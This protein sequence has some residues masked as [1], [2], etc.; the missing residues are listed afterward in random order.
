M[1]TILID[2]TAG[3]RGQVE[4]RVERRSEQLAV[5]GPARSMGPEDLGRGRSEP[6]RATSRFNQRGLNILF[7]QGYRYP[8]GASLGGFTI[9]DVEPTQFLSK[10][11]RRAAFG[12][13]PSVR[14]VR[15]QRTDLIRYTRT[16]PAN[17]NNEDAT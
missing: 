12:A 16:A 9:L 17:E 15:A 5:G 10:A 3:G 4:R 13:C 8:P 7:V 11:C 14:A 1:V 6:I 2:A